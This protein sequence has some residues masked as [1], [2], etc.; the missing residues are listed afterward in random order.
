MDVVIGSF[1]EP[2]DVPMLGAGPMYCFE[3][4]LV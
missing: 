1:A 3:V 4:V 2:V